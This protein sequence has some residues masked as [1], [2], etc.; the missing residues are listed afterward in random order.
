MKLP[1][2]QKIIGDLLD[3]IRDGR[4]APDAPMPSDDELQRLYGT[5]RITVQRALQELQTMGLVK[6][7]RG[8][9]T[10]V[11]K[12]EPGVP[13][14]RPGAEGHPA[15]GRVRFITVIFPQGED[16]GAHTILLG[17]EEAFSESDCIVGIKNSKDSVRNERII[18][19][20]LL[21]QRP[22]GVIL[23]ATS[24]SHKNIDL[25]SRFLA[26]AIPLVL[27][28]RKAAY[29]DT[30][31]VACDN[32]LGTKTLV[33]YLVSKGRR[34]IAFIGSSLEHISSEQE[35]FAGYCQGLALAGMGVDMGLVRLVGPHGPD[36]YDR[37]ETDLAAAEVVGAGAD[38]IVAVN[39]L[40]A[41]ALSRSLRVSGVSVPGQVS[42]VGFDDIEFSR[43]VRP[44][45]TTYKQ[46]FRE[47]GAKAGQILQEIMEGTR[48]QATPMEIRVQGNLV[49]RDSA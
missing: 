34:K 31:F 24:E 19:E 21:V 12:P 47:I 5:S 45:I 23:F 11:L 42:I 22:S 3:Q 16:N 4:L 1:L 39:D 36:Q 35:R 37:K 9:G 13:V 18:M 49:V 48:D 46:P 14:P 44:G 25:I 2:Y 29:I 20:S 33:D 6:R 28:D 40:L 43:H 15:P 10:F 7:I 32:R 26:E 27:I 30:P 8:H 17:I 41:I 38:A